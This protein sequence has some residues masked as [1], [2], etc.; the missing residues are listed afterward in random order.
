MGECV[1]CLH[2]TTRF[3]VL[4]S[5]AYSDC[6]C[7]CACVCKSSV[8]MV[9]ATVTF[10]LNSTQSNKKIVCFQYYINENISCMIFPWHVSFY[11]N[12]SVLL[13]N[14]SVVLTLCVVIFRDGRLHAVLSAVRLL[15]PNK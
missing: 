13:R 1:R 3:Q 10:R 12:E 7:V 2:H 5:E 9:N 15:L 6:V 4:L 11:R 8:L 14:L